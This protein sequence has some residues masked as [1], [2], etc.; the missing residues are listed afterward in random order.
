[1]YKLK[2]ERDGSIE[3][4]KG[5]VLDSLF[6]AYLSLSSHISTFDKNYRYLE[7]NDALQRNNTWTLVIVPPNHKVINCKWVYKLKLERDGSMKRHKGCVLD[8][9]FT[10]YLS[11]SSHIST[12][13]KNYRYLEEN[14]VLQRNNT[15]T[16]VL[17]PP[18]HKVIG[19]KWV[20]KLKLERDGSIRRHK[21]CL[22]DSLFTSYFSLFFHISTFDKNYRYLEENDVLQRN[23][24]WNLVLVPPNHK[25]IG[26]K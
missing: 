3:R 20:Y 19:C 2:L 8:S 7:E 6:T 16:L 11:L 17:V 9:L 5:C 18:N 10:V 24:T 12:F 23:N 14:D 1:M 25:V 15:W 13:D 22:L 21:G 4:H 26:C